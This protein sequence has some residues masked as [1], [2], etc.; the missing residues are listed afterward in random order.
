MNVEILDQPEREIDPIKLMCCSY[1]IV[2]STVPP[3]NFGIGK[4]RLGRIAKAKVAA[5]RSKSIKSKVAA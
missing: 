1:S 5:K 4:N 2:S 3:P